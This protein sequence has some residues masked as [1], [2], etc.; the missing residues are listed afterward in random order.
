MNLS[1][2][3][4]PLQNFDIDYTTGFN[5]PS[6]NLKKKNATTLDKL[7]SKPNKIKK[8]VY[9]VR[10][11]VQLIIEFNNSSMTVIKKMN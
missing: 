11:P 2:N 9:E 8:S 6:K 4:C 5:D 7:N 10:I 1:R 3:I